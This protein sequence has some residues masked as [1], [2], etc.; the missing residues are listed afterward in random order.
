MQIEIIG[1]ILFVRNS[2]YILVFRG[3]IY[4]SNVGFAYLLNET[5]ISSNIFNSYKN[6]KFASEWLKYQS[7]ICTYFQENK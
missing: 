6:I 7:S 5:F 2:F 1:D 4:I 3:N